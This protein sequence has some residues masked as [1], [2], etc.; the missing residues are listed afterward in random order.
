[1]Q[2]STASIPI[3]L[4]ADAAD[5]VLVGRV[6]RPEV[7][8]PALVAVRGADL[9]DLSAHAWTFA[10]LLDRPDLVEVARNAPGPSLGPVQA[11]LA[12]SVAASRMNRMFNAP[13]GGR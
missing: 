10:E 7:A 11:V 6:W 13:D 2:N 12:N 9:V 5:A 4:P 8:G 1:M 3:G